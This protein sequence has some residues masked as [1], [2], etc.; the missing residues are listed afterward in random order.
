MEETKNYYCND[1]TMEFSDA[2]DESMI[3]VEHGGIKKYRDVECEDGTIENV[4]IGVHNSTVCVNHGGV[5]YYTGLL[6]PSDVSQIG[7][8]NALRIGMVVGLSL[9]AYF[10]IRAY[11]KNN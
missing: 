6:E 4:P 7:K 5:K 8:K 11:K 3:C 1:G 9:V 10:V 2:I